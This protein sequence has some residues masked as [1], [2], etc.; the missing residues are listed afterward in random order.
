MLPNK[1]EQ[2][3]NAAAHQTPSMDGKDTLPGS[4]AR[5]LD[6]RDSLCRNHLPACD[7]EAAGLGESKAPRGFC[8]IAPSLEL[9]LE[10]SFVLG[11]LAPRAIDGHIRLAAPTQA[12]KPGQ[13]EC[14]AAVRFATESMRSHS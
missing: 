8:V 6:V 11:E 14:H 5:R 9:G 10:S 12:P 2:G 7:G 1:G 3:S 13:D 4:L